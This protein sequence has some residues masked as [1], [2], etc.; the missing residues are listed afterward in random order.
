MVSDGAQSRVRSDLEVTLCADDDIE[1]VV[2]FGSW[3]ADTPREPSDVDVAIKFSEDLSASE[4]FAKRCFLAGDLQREDA[5]FVDVS[6]I[7]RL[8]LDVAND[9]IDGELLCGD[10]AA[11]R[12]Y[13]E[14]VRAQFTENRE[15]I[16][17]RQR[18]VIDRIAEHGL[19]G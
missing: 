16:R 2:V 1:F 12:A 9:A 11:F 13:R 19:H 4:Q 3:V 8:P 18:D 10:D 6:D 5:P 15:D 17:R 14:R 7:D